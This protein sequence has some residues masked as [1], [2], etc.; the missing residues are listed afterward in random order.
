MSILREY[1]SKTEAVVFDFDDT[2]VDETHSIKGRWDIVLSEYEKKLNNKNLKSTFFKIFNKKGK[3]YRFHV[4]DAIHSCG[5]NIGFK[6]EIVKAFLNQDSINESLLPK[7]TDVCKLLSEQKNFK[8]AIFTNGIRKTHHK[9][10]KLSGV[11]KYFEY[12]QYGDCLKPKPFDESFIL[13]S[14]KLK[15]NVYNNFI[16]IG[17]SYKDD[18]LGAKSVQAKCILINSNIKPNK[19]NIVFR[20]MNDFY[21]NLK[22]VL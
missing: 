9:R 21:N 7:V 4:D 3:D 13:L 19:D 18:Y 5:I 2:L 1:F 14:K 20:N 16:M 17:D 11:E 8:M 12:I 15:L 10:I 6:N 22:D